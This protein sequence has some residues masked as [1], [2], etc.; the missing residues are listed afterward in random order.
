MQVEFLFLK[1]TLRNVMLYRV[2]D[3]MEPRSIPWV[4]NSWLR[5]VMEYIDLGR[6]TC[7]WV[8]LLLCL[9]TNVI[10]QGAP[11]DIVWMEE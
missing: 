1:L 6:Q 2:P 11:K 4:K 9:A 8:S 3:S 7:S 10:G 5:R